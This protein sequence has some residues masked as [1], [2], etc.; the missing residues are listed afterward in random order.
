MA[1]IFNPFIAFCTPDISTYL[2]INI[3]SHMTVHFDNHDKWRE[4]NNT[5]CTLVFPLPLI[6][7]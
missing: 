3:A 2:C 5:D 4:V 1:K 7:T 6:E